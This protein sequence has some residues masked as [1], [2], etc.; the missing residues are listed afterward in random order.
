M[1]LLIR[2]YPLCVAYKNHYKG[3]LIQEMLQ[4]KAVVTANFAVKKI[5]PTANSVCN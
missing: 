2:I 4:E 5:L 1:N 3:T